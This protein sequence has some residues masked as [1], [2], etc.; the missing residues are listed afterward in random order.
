MQGLSLSAGETSGAF[1]SET[2]GKKA[3]RP[4]NAPPRGVEQH[5]FDVL[6]CRG[7]IAQADLDLS[8][9]GAMGSG[10]DVESLLLDRYHVPKDVLG[11]ILSD[12]Y[13]CPYLPFDERTVIDTDL[14]RPLNHDYLKKHLW[15]P[16]ARRAQLLDVLT[17]DPHDL[18]QGWDVRRTFPGMTIRYSVGLRRD[19]EQFLGA[20]SA[21]GTSGSIGAILG[22]LINEIHLESA[23]DSVSEAIDENDSAIVRL[24][25]QVIA[26]A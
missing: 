13:Q 19:I 3:G 17:H 25:N 21:P 26:E 14:V 7:I 20:L 1:P 9:E 24:I 11:A 10:T 4:A 15:L 16:V 18:E 12:Y 5:V 6:V 22:E 8:V 23:L 2:A